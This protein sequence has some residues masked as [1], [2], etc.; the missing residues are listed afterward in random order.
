[1]IFLST[2]LVSQLRRTVDAIPG[3]DRR[4]WNWK[5]FL[6]HAA[7]YSKCHFASKYKDV[8]TSPTKGQRMIFNLLRIPYMWKG[9]KVSWLDSESVEMEAQTDESGA[10]DI[11][12]TAVT[13]QA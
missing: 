1:M 10:Q 13:D 6:R 3:N 11:A 5:E 9:K 12:E 2:I 8:Y 7:S 4:W